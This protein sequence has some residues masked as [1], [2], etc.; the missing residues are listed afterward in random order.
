MS[1]AALTLIPSLQREK[2]TPSTVRI[3]CHYV[4]VEQFKTQLEGILKNV[5]CH[6]KAKEDLVTVIERLREIRSVRE[7]INIFD[8]TVWYVAEFTITSNGGYL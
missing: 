2:N 8:Y 7:T 3:R 1:I 4:T 5:K 6:P